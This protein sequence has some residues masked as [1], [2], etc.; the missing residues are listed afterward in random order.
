MTRVLSFPNEH[1]NPYFQLF[2]DALAPYD[3]TVSYASRVA[4]IREALARAPFDVLHL[5]WSIP[6]LWRT[7]R[8]RAERIASGLRERADSL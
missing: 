3:V 4:E 6:R 5:H 1:I 2:Y 8:T 7:G